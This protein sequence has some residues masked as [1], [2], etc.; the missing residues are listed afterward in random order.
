MK[1]LRLEAKSGAASEPEGNTRG[2][3]LEKLRL[4]AS[5]DYD[6]SWLQAILYENPELLPI[7][8]IDAASRSFLPLCREFPLLSEGRTVFLD[9]LGVTDSG[10][11]VLIECKL[12]R[13]PQ[14][15]REVIGQALEYAGLLQGQTCGDL[16][17]RLK[18][19][20]ETASNNP[21]FEVAKARWPELDETTFT[22]AVSNSLS[23]GD[24]AIVIAGD[25]IRADLRSISAYLDSQIGVMPR[26]AL[27][28]LQIWKGAGGETVVLP[29]IPVRTEVI[30]QRV[31]TDQDSRPLRIENPVDT[32]DDTESI[33]DPEAGQQKT[34][35]RQF[36][37]RFIGKLK[38]DHS[39][40]PGPRHGGNNYVRL[41]LP[42]PAQSLTVY[43]TRQGDA[44][45]FI[46]F[47]MKNDPEFALSTYERLKG[48]QADLSKEV[49]LTLDF[50]DGVIDGSKSAQLPQ[51]AARQ[52][53]ATGPKS[54]NEQLE[55]LTRITNTVVNALRPRL[56][57]IA[58]EHA[59]A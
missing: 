8:E 40:Q 15:R 22:D 52:A 49:G 38:L 2:E 9:L 55:W 41:A 7:H 10:R 6:E 57:A 31:L 27:V 51:I 47:E 36:W 21:L 24:F 18:K 20:L 23:R 48:E 39:D 34:R 19:R 12:W 35:N 44:G 37:D 13:N 14:A 11:L 54:D 32:A 45:F 50:R 16:N 30:E 56:S 25:G 26:I 59:E 17:V 1:A 43:R 58:R 29:S 4:T 28:E 5:D 46:R 3:I 42:G 33:T 53:F